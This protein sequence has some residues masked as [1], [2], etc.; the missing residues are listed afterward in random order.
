MIAILA[1]HRVADAPYRY[2]VSPARFAE[3]LALL[4]RRGF[5][6]VRASEL[7]A[8][9]NSGAHRG[10]RL[11]CLTFDDGYLDN[12]E[13]AYPLLVER[14]IPAAIFVAT[15]LAGAREAPGFTAPFLMWGQMREMQASGLVEF[16]NHTRSHPD[17]TTLSAGEVE[18][19][20]SGA[21]A[22]ISRELGR[23]A[24]IIAYPKGR[25]NPQVAACAARHGVLAMGG[26]GLITDTRVPSRYALPRIPVYR[27]D[28]LAKF[29]LRLRPL[30]WRL[31][32]AFGRGG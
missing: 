4:A 31:R 12:Y 30:F 32:A 13:H 29:A 17:L 15:G 26:A 23:E 2:S 16:E 22:D 27:E 10:R 9:L 1:Y 24:T 14:G 6:F 19:E 7:P 11:A 20:F 3:Q 21:R 5:A 28:S 25:F 8:L 18:R